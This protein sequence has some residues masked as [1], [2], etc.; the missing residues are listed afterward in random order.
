M[1]VLRSPERRLYLSML[2][3][4]DRANSYSV[5]S[6]S[7]CPQFIHY[8]RFRAPI[9][10]FLGRLEILN[11]QARVVTAE[12]SSRHARFDH[13]TTLESAA[14]LSNFIL[15]E[16]IIQA[17]SSLFFSTRDSILET[18]V[19]TRNLKFS[20]LE[21]QDSRDCQLTFERYCTPVQR[22]ILGDLGPLTTE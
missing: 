8:R 10:N 12:M 2:I 18:R 20:S 16:L 21:D 15:E 6:G 19:E 9:S 22:K 3:R 7:I 4:R 13:S 1:F 17:T 11:D 5:T 14:R